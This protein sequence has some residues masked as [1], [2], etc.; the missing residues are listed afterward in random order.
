[1]QRIY[2]SLT[3]LRFGSA[4]IDRIYDD[5]V[6]LEVTAETTETVA[7]VPLEKQI[8]L[9]DV[10]FSYDQS[11]RRAVSGVNI[12]IPLRSTVAFVGPTGSGK[13]T[14]VDVLLGLLAP[15][16]G[17]LRL[18]D[19]VIGADNVRGWQQNLGY[20][21]QHIGF[22]AE[23]PRF[24]THTAGSLYVCSRKSTKSC[25]NRRRSNSRSPSARALLAIASRVRGSS[26]S[27]CRA[28]A[29]SSG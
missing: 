27:R 4:A 26:A 6:S 12:T 29:S 22:D 17:H 16:E 24:L 11:G 2:G 19:T 7:T 3:N 13:T 14:F 21:P 25:A 20:V 15:T 9:V 8:C 23:T 18:D 5:M 1:M 10:G 28:S